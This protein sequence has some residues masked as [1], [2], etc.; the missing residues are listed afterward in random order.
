MP[1]IA[2]LKEPAFGWVLRVCY[3]MPTNSNELCIL[4]TLTFSTSSGNIR[5]RS[6]LSPTDLLGAAEGQFY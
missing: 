1:G 3:L 4:V 6:M 2:S 5:P